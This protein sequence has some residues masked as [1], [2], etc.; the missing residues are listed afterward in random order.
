MSS[1]ASGLEGEVAMETDSNEK[2]ISQVFSPVKGVE[3][4][5]LCCST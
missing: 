3:S 1:V 2:I 4:N 5:E